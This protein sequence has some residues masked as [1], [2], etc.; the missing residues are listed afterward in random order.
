MVV[1]GVMFNDAIFYGIN[2]AYPPSIQAYPLSTH[3][4]PPPPTPPPPSPEHV[5]LQHPLSML[6][7]G[8]TSSGKSYWMNKLLTHAKTMINPPP[9]RMT[10]CYKRWQP[11]LSLLLVAS[12]IRSSMT[13]RLGYL[14]SM[15]ESSFQSSGIPCTNTIFFI[16]C[17]ISLNRGCHL[18]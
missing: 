13:I 18:L 10:W 7:C 14:V 2:Q 16:V 4:Y 3:A 5:V 9:E 6:V 17:C 11:L 1:F 8:P 15:K 12:L